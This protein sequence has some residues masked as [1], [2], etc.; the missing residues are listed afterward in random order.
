MDQKWDG[1]MLRLNGWIDDL[2]PDG[3]QDTE[4]LEWAVSELSRLAAE[5]E[6]LMAELHRC[7]E[8][9]SP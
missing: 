9:V 1:M 8:K 5:N 7:R 4:M 6:R 3:N 2:G